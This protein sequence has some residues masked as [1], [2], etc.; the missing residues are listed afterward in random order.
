MKAK[1]AILSLFL[2]MVILLSCSDEDGKMLFITYPKNAGKLEQFAAREISKYIYLRT[3]ELIKTKEAGENKTNP[4]IVLKI[5][6]SYGKEEFSLISGTSGTVKSLEIKGGSPTA[7]LYGAYE[8]AEQLGVRFY[9][10]GD[11]VPDR[12]VPFEIPDLNIRKKPLFSI[13]G[14]Q[15]FHDFPEGPDWWDTQDYKAIISQLP[16]LKMNF[17]GFH[18]YPENIKFAGDGNK[19][20]PMVW[21]GTGDQLNSDGTV[22]SAYPVLHFNTM[23]E[24]WGYAPKKT[25]DYTFGTSQFFPTDKYG[26]RYMAG[27]SPWPHSDQENIT[28]FNE[29]GKL[30]KEVFSYASGLGVKTCIGTETS[31]IIPENVKKY[32]KDKGI[33]PDS[34]EARKRIY[35][36]I[37]DR[38]KK[39]HPLD[40]YWFWTPE[41]WTW[42][43]VKQEEVAAVE[44]D[45]RIA[46]E[47]AGTEKVPF[48]LATCGW[49]IGPPPDRARFDQI[50]PKNMPFSC[51]NRNVGFEPIDESFLRISGREKWAIPWLE[52]D[53]ALI[54]P[55]LWAGR[56]RRDAADALAFGCTGLIG[57][58]WRTRELGPNVSALAKAA[59]SQ[60]WNPALEEKV[61]PETLKGYKH[62]V[63]GGDSLLRDMKT[64]DFYLDWAAA[65][66][67]IANAGKI[68]SIFTEIDGGKRTLFSKK[69]E[70]N[71]PRPADWFHGPGGIVADTTSWT[72]KEKSYAFVDSL[73]LLRPGIKGAGS[74]ERFDFW[75]NQFRYL[76]ETGRLS[77][78]LGKYRQ[79]GEK[80]K[81]LSGEKQ[82]ESAEKNLVPIRKEMMNTL[83]NIHRYLLL[84]VTSKGT[85][86]TMTN[87]QQHV[88]KFYIEEPGRE[89]ASLT[90]RALL[91]EELPDSTI[92]IK[93]IN[94]ISPPQTIEAG[95]NFEVLLLTLNVKNPEGAIYFRPPGKKTFLSIPLKNEGR[96]VL[97]ATIP[98]IHLKYDFEYYIEVKSAGQV[99]KVFPP[100]A[101]MLNNMVTIR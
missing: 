54:I 84:T 4:G 90:G 15:P 100:T 5:D 40:Y 29:F 55:Q 69:K 7:V 93:T 94:L 78:L 48:T 44:K 72:E 2:L 3:G 71:L 88:N 35:R 32:L 75:L 30:Q 92:D 95:D 28:I 23:D 26:A 41:T 19:A 34:D 91:P 65:H 21:I 73:E 80:I 43:E 17:I 33:D 18:T 50:L 60:D 67:G 101:P 62:I 11:V 96:G 27:T 68:A 37:F 46:V 12:Q 52:D 57:I 97:S 1:Y 70:S 59:W 63:T 66:F 83:R 16:K 13:R 14:I 20:E 25:T 58:H 31:L 22:K 10:E 77:C 82:K 39:T 56:M 53:P 85:L 42:G 86:G 99:E 61:T 36:G 74:L 81:I 24:S 9:L 64:D 79:A 51:I 6:Q 76:R 45:L 47:A 38:I 87:W 49:V 98:G 8:F 89:L